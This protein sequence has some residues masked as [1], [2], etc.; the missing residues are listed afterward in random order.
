MFRR[1]IVKLDF[2]QDHGAAFRGKFGVE[3]GEA[4]WR[5][6]CAGSHRARSRLPELRFDSAD[7]GNEVV[8]RAEMPKQELA[9]RSLGQC[10]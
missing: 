10:E 6:T 8:V 4:F 9:G 2:D 7:D 1:I 5:R 3:L